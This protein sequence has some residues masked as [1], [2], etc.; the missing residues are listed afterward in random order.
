MIFTSSRSSRYRHTGKKRPLKKLFTSLSAVAIIFILFF[1]S[2]KAQKKPEIE[3]TFACIDSLGKVIAIE[4]DRL[5][6]TKRF[7][8]RRDGTVGTGQGLFQALGNLGLSTRMGLQLVNA[9]SDSVELINMAVGERISIE[10]DPKDT[11]NVLLFSYAPNPAIIH[12]LVNQDGN[13]VYQKVEHPTTIRYR[14]VEGVLEQGSSLD[15][16]LRE[17]GIAPSMVAVVNGVLLCK[18]A[19]RTHARHGDRFQVLLRERFF[20]DSIR[21]EGQVMYTCYEGLKAGFHEA[22]RYDDGDPKSSYTAHYTESGEALIHSGLRYPL[23]RLHISS[24][25]GMRHHPV[26]GRRTMHEGVDYRASTGTPVY[27]VAAGV[28]VQSGYNAA[29]GNYIAIRHAD[30][31]T[32]YY[33][34]LHKRLIKAGQTV[35]TRQLIGNVGNTGISTGPHLHF[36]FRKPDG[37]WMDPLRKR[38]IA[39]PKLEG[40]KFVALGMQIRNV[41]NLL[42]SLRTES[43][44]VVLK[45]HDDDRCEGCDS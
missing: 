8:C 26:T 7:M 2:K 38:M 44:S 42:D 1:I 3:T 34:H 21:I 28:V 35:R 17:K 37:S 45:N 6:E 19:F 14:L 18:I 4:E 30:R 22:F 29:N 27:S 15:Q 33:L 39:T 11:T 40:E 10:L 24:G 9:L 5:T 12:Q 20:Q 23:D 25:Y 31:Y 16:T 36:G 43:Q 41:R 13:F 32:S